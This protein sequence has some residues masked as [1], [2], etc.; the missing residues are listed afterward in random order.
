MGHCLCADKALRIVLTY[1]RAEALEVPAEVRRID[2][3]SVVFH[4]A[5]S[6][7]GCANTV[8]IRVFTVSPLSLKD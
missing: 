8:V 7:T 2:A 5:H 1:A 6:A 4:I 3:G